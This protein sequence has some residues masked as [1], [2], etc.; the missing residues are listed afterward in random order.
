MKF[1]ARGITVALLFALVASSA[2]F[3]DTYHSAAFSGQLGSS[4][5]IK[6]P[7]N[8]VL[9]GGGAVSGNFVYD[10]QL[11]PPAASGFVNVFFSSFPD[12]ASIPESTAFT[13]DLGGGLVFTLADAL[14]GSGAIQYNNGNFNGFSFVSDFMFQSNPYELTVSGGTFNVVAVVN[15]YPQFSN[16]VSGT[17]NIGNNNLT[18]TSV[19]VPGISPSVPEPS[20]LLLFGAGIA[21]L[22][23][24]LKRKLRQSAP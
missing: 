2:S 19:Y 15:G 1:I 14:P 11:T 13:L 20:S 17:L 12:I 21:A 8:S 22:A 24:A 4:P 6:S 9:S 3:A 18:S 23:G 7:F 10:D 5:N 16:F